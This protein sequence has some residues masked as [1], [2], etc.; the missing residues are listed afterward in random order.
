ML[1]IVLALAG[2]VLVGND[3]PRQ[4]AVLPVEADRPVALRPRQVPRDRRVVNLLDHAPRVLLWLEAGLL[5]DW[6]TYYLDNLDLLLGILGY[7]LVLTV[8][9]AACWSSRRPCG[10]GGRCRW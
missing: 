4:P 6:Q 2:S 1:V 7:G 10:C 5:Y 9:A 3:F 8:D